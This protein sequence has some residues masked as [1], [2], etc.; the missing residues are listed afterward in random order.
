MKE[1]APL[2]NV[3]GSKRTS[4]ETEAPLKAKG[5][6]TFIRK[7]ICFINYKYINETS[8]PHF[9]CLWLFHVI[10]MNFLHMHGI[11]VSIPLASPPPHISETGAIFPPPFPLSF[12]KQARISSPQLPV[13]DTINGAQCS[14]TTTSPSTPLAATIKGTDH[15]TSGG[16]AT[17]WWP[18]PTQLLIFG[19][20]HDCISSVASL[21]TAVQIPVFITALFFLPVGRGFLHHGS[22]NS[23]LPPRR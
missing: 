20:K 10:K 13:N 6:Q 2:K 16:F 4:D 21:Y 11:Q 3:R 23:L 14:P 22:F 1:E 19:G 9:C 5:T 12:H 18:V 7:V 15:G 17:R 8:I